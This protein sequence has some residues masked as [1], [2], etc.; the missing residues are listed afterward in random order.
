MNKGL[1]VKSRNILLGHTKEIW[2]HIIFVSFR[3]NFENINLKIVQIVLSPVEWPPKKTLRVYKVTTFKRFIRKLLKTN[4]CFEVNQWEDI[5]RMT[6]TLIK[7]YHRIYNGK[8]SNN[9]KP[10]SLGNFRV[11]IS[12]F[13]IG[14]GWYKHR[15]VW[16]KICNYNIGS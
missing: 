8:V 16:H 6:W 9:K 12:Q 2:N 4:K 11:A 3:G 7:R 15:K 5:K 1:V 14:L 10:K 13:N